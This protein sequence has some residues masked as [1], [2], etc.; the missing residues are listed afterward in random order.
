MIRL[1]NDQ[2]DKHILQEACNGQ[3]SYIS[4]INGNSLDIMLSDINMP[5][6]DGLPLF[7]QITVEY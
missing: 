2:L 5:Y 1:M 7:Q 6:M 4:F 3:I